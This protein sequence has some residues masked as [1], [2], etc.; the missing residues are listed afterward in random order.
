MVHLSRCHRTLTN[1]N[2]ATVFLT[3]LDG[4]I[5]IAIV[6]HVFKPQKPHT[7]SR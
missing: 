6:V 3:I 1:L 2:H 5:N 4:K 7:I